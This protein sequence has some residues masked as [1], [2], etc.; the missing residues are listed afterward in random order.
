MIL[1]NDN[2]ACGLA[3]AASGG[4]LIALDPRRAG[5]AGWLSRPLSQAQGV[6][7]VML[8]ISVFTPMF[9]NNKWLGEVGRSHCT[10]PNSAPF[11]R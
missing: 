1:R 7:M 2:A 11:R 8:W 3:G 9:I 10:V 6:V 4:S 5:G